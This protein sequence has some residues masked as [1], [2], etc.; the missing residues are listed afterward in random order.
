[1]T[2]IF[3]HKRELRVD[4]SDFSPNVYKLKDIDCITL[5]RARDMDTGLSLKECKQ[6]GNVELFASTMAYA[7]TTLGLLT[8]GE[9]AIVSAP[10]RRHRGWH[11]SSEVCRRLGELLDVPFIDR[12][13]VAVNRSRLD[14]WMMLR[15]ELPPN[16]LVVD[17][18]VTT[19]STL[20]GMSKRLKDRNA[21]Y[22]AGISNR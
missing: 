7:V 4:L 9:W 8:P 13:F 11:F 12:A 6:P 3:S 10:R 15:A 5:W 1:M 20:I 18:I 22:L 2:R 14:P 19:G 17:D 21:V 16:V